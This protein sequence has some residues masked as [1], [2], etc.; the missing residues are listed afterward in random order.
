MYKNH[1]Y[2][3]VFDESIFLPIFFVKILPLTTL[4]QHDTAR[5]IS[6]TQRNNFQLIG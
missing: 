4:S 2:N 1:N 6:S 5:L 3:L